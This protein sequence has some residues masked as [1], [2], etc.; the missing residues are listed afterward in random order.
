MD[1]CMGQR[2]SRETVYGKLPTENDSTERILTSPRGLESIQLCHLT[3]VR[4]ISTKGE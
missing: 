2:T 4:H 3:D 1:I